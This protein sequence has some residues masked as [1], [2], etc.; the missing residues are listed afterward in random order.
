MDLM[1]VTISAALVFIMQVGFL[2]LESGLVRSKNSINVAV[3]NVT[4][5]IISS[6][7]FGL[8]GFALMFGSSYSGVFGT[9]YF[10]FDDITHP[11]T[12]TFFLFQ[13]MFCS[14]AATLVSG[15]V[16]ERMHYFG[17]IITT[18][19]ITALIYPFVGHWIWGGALDGAAAGWLEQLGFIDFAGSTVVHS[20]GGWVSLAA[21]LI[22]GPRLG[23]Y[24]Q[25]ERRIPGGNIP[26]ASVGALI[27]WFGWIG[28]NGGSTLAWNEHVPVILLNTFVSAC[29]GAII[30]TAIKYFKHGYIDLMYILNGAIG[31]LVAITACCHVVTPHSA[32]LIGIGAGIVVYLG[33]DFLNHFKIDDVI[34]VV[35]AHLFAGVWGTLSVALFASD[36]A[37]GNLRQLGVQALGIIVVGLFSFAVAYLVLRTINHFYKLRVSE[38]EEHQGL[39][40]VEHKISTEVFDLLTSMDQQSRSSGFKNAVPVEPFTEVGQIARLYNQ[41]LDKVNEEMGQKDIAFDAFKRSELRN[42]AILE[43]AMDCIIT[44]DQ[45]GKI[46]DIN[47]AAEKTFNTTKRYVKDKPFFEMFMLPENLQQAI[48]SLAEGFTELPGLILRKRNMM[49]LLRSDKTQFPAE[50]VITKTAFNDYTNTEYTLYIRDVAKRIKLERRLQSLAFNDP[51]TGL[52]NRSYFMTN[53]KN[54]IDFHKLNQGNISLMFLDLD[55]FKKVNDT[56]GHKAGDALLCEVA[57]RLTAVSREEDMVGRWGGD[58]FVVIISGSVTEKIMKKRAEKVLNIMKTPMM[59]EKNELSIRVSIGVAISY[60]GDVSGDM[61]LQQADIAMYQAKQAGKDTYRIYGKE[62]SKA[63]EHAF[64]IEYA[65]PNALK[66]GQLYLTFQPKVL[67]RNN[68]I[69]GFEALTRW[70][71]PDYGMITPDEFVPILETSN[72]IVTLGEWVITETFKQLVLMKAQGYGDIPIAVNISGKHIH[73]PKLLSHI[74]AKAK[75][76]GIHPS[77]LEIEITEG[78]LASDI[79]SSIKAMQRLADND[80]NLSID[81]FGTGYSS[82]SYLRKFPIKVLKIDRAFIMNCAD[83]K[84][85]A[86][87]CLA[88]ISLAKSLSLEIVAEGVETIEQL[89]FLKQYDCAYQGYYFSKPLVSEEMLLLL[90]DTSLQKGNDI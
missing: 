75:Q 77:L 57:K 58:E 48:K 69:I 5:F 76:Y 22:L 85:D 24:D 65:L 41:V 60:A 25:S 86:A 63:T 74:K 78:M 53:L 35:P 82:L 37:I 1:W 44:I 18:V 66:V 8:V 40:I 81:D 38:A 80:I 23:R 49:E 15:A 39:N 4:D 14:T 45:L 29:W 20:V 70:K 16:A 2:C 64:N 33:E 55:G 83:D 89:T 50:I 62:M 51:L 72:L 30:A 90:N 3:K 61:L 79:D 9:E 28:F 43:A 19:V 52:Y 68:K 88:I 31:G 54:R 71:H 7:L 67:C 46:L 59:V 17:Y 6:S 56:L 87:I 12:A 36:P 11:K 34:G 27:I 21:L 32:I 42:G 84:D 73:N 47:P 26:L 10:F 13:M